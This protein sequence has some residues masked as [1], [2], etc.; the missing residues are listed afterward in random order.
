MLLVGQLQLRQHKAAQNADGTAIRLIKS[1]PSLPATCLLF[2]AW[3]KIARVGL[4]KLAM[5]FEIMNYKR[6][7]SRYFTAVVLA[8]ISNTKCRSPYR[9]V[10]L[11][12]ISY[13]CADPVDTSLVHKLCRKHSSTRHKADQQSFYTRLPPEGLK[14]YLHYARYTTFIC[15]YCHSP[16]LGQ[17]CRKQKEH[18]WLSQ[19]HLHNLLCPEVSMCNLPMQPILIRDSMGNSSGREMDYSVGLTSDSQSH[20]V[21]H[22]RSQSHFHWGGGG[23]CVTKTGKAAVQA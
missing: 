16:N 15:V 6:Q 23:W 12:A 11:Q 18:G 5:G 1:D 19:L 17:K 4:K 8:C 21:H 14:T 20:I 2:A 22:W 9:T 13:L 3:L 10:G 7:F